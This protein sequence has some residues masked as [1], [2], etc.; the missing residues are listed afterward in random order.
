M[1][2]PQEAGKV[3]S[4]IVDAMKSQPMV[5]A[6]LLFNALILGIILW[7][8]KDNRTHQQEVM[9]SILSQN[10]KFIDLLTKCLAGQRT[11]DDE[12][13]LP[14][15]RPSDLEMKEIPG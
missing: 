13:P 11:E 3:A 5:L 9:K 6:V 10:D 15:P 2:L 1:S 4:S 12:I 7:G 8:V 14:R